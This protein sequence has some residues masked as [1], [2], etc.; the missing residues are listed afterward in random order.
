MVNI[1]LLDDN[2][3][4][5]IFIKKLISE[6]PIVNNVFDTSS[7][8]EAIDFARE[9]KPDIAFLDIKLSPEER[10]NG[11]QV[12]KEI[13]NFSPDIYFVF[14][15]GYPQ[16]AIESFAVHPFDYILKPIEK[17]KI[18]G[19]INYLA[20]KIKKMN[21]E[22]SSLEKLRIKIRG[23][24]HLI[25]FN[26]ILFIEKQNKISLLHTEK[27]IYEIPYQTLNEL[28][29]KLGSNFLRVHKSFIANIN[30]VSRIREVSNR[31]YEIDF[32]GYDKV[33]FMSRYK[34]EEH[35]NRFIPL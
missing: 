6:N 1:L 18:K 34:F 20:D 24:I 28:M 3:Y 5:R 26:D 10:L 12:A 22:K 14:I 33:A 16:Y 7:G 11:I 23:E 31:S 4:T 13:H 2:Y 21:S 9:H 29:E 35:K 19:T 30:K 15:T 8:K 25:P 32:K 27:T 17:E